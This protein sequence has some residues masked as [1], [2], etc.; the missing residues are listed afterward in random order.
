MLERRNQR[1]QT[2]HCVM[3]YKESCEEIK[4]FSISRQ[5][6]SLGVGDKS[7]KIHPQIDRMFHQLLSAQREINLR[8]KTLIILRLKYII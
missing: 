5:K 2:K 4:S 1:K 3:P 7:N 6:N 8:E